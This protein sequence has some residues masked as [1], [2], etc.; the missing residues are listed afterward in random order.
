MDYREE[1]TLIRKYWM[2]ETSLEEER[3]LRIFFRGAPENLD[4]EL[5]EAAPLFAFWDEEEARHCPPLQG[6]WKAP[7]RRRPGRV[8][9]LDR[10]W[11]YA[12]FLLLI[13]GSLWMMRPGKLASNQA[14]SGA[15]VI[16]DPQEAWK[17]TRR[18]LEILAANLNKGKDQ[19]EKLSLFHQAEQAVR[20]GEVERSYLRP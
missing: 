15:R 18:A 1:K 6:P 10:Y 11:E 12:A 16:E 2:G 17:A 7:S 19:M 14:A 3:R 9:R 8:R 4:S 5:L 13:L 20:S